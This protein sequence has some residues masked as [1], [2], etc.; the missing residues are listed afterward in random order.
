MSSEPC[1]GDAESAAACP[2]LRSN[3]A[4]HDQW[5]APTPARSTMP[6]EMAEETVDLATKSLRA[7]FT[8]KVRR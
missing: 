1:V 5:P 7:E 6:L 3:L 2:G 8:E 4:G